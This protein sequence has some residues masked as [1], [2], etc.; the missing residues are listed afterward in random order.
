MYLNKENITKELNNIDISKKGSV[1]KKLNALFE[2]EYI[3]KDLFLND[4][5]EEKIREMIDKHRV[6]SADLEDLNIN[7]KNAYRNK[8][9]NEKLSADEIRTFK[10]FWCSRIKK[11]EDLNY[12]KFSDINYCQYYLDHN[13]PEIWNFSKDTII[14]I[15][16]KTNHIINAAKKRG[17]KN[18]IIVYD[19]I[20]QKEISKQNSKKIMFK[21]DNLNKISNLMILNGRENLR[22]IIIFDK[23]PINQKIAVQLEN[24]LKQDVNRKNSIF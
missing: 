13:L 19:N 1:K 21:T 24:F 7:F 3:L 18:F 20:L 5:E 22:N 23:N 17:Q 2:L 11:I 8:S 16:P 15:N 4:A 6:L 9:N 12:Q 14:V 10:S